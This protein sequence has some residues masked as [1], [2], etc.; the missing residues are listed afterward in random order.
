MPYKSEA[1]ECAS[2]TRIVGDPLIGEQRK[3]FP[4]PQ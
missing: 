2:E 1:P 3:R 4:E